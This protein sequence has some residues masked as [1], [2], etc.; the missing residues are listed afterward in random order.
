M[1]SGKLV[2]TF[3]LDLQSF[4]ASVLKR[5]CCFH[6]GVLGMVGMTLNMFFSSCASG[7]RRAETKRALMRQ[8]FTERRILNANPQHLCNPLVTRTSATNIYQLHIRFRCIAQIWVPFSCNPSH[9]LTLTWLVR[10]QAQTST[11]SSQLSVDSHRP[12]TA[13]MAMSCCLKLRRLPA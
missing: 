5:F 2:V 6:A 11:S 10:F 4:D 13:K 7:L 1:Q 9:P 3:M 8:R 12:R